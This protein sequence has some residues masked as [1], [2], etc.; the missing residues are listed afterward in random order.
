M[1]RFIIMFTLLVIEL[2]V[3]TNQASA[4]NK[5]GTPQ[6][7]H[8]NFDSFVL[9]SARSSDLK[10]FLPAL[11]NS[12]PGKLVTWENMLTAYSQEWLTKKGALSDRQLLHQLFYDVHR[13]YL[14]KFT[15]Y[16]GLH[17]LLKSGEYN[18]LSATAFYALLLE[19]LDYKYEIIESVNHVVLLVKLQ[20]G[21]LILL[22]STDPANGFLADK[23]AVKQRLQAIRDSEQAAGYYNLNLRIFRAIDLRELAGLQYYNY[24]AWYYNQRNMALAADYLRKGQL[25]YQSERFEKI[26]HL[27]ANP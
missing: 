27:M 23:H 14:K 24:A 16:T 2:G 1:A 8:Q 5:R 7:L 9:L 15:Q 21:Q 12:K 19:R 20:D 13:L 11:A 6:P 22:E 18:C 4:A 25:L 10:L 17:A 26:A 3:N